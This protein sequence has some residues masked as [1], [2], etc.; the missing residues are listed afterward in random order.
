MPSTTTKTFKYVGVSTL[1]GRTKVRFANALA[2]IKMMTKLGHDDIDL[3]KLP[4]AMM[5]PTAVRYLMER[6]NSF[7]PEGVSAIEN[8]D[9]KYNP[10]KVT[11]GRGV[12]IG[13][14]KV[15]QMN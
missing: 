4:R 5:K 9:E 12:R 11:K 7:E 1:N 6:L 3:R 14:T 8:A 10:I 2:R 13:G 15:S